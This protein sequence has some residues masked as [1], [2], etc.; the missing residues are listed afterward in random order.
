MS[1]A[2]PVVQMSL[3]NERLTL[4]RLEQIYLPAFPQPRQRKAV[5]S[6]L[7][8]VHSLCSINPLDMTLKYPDGTVSISTLGEL[9]HYFVCGEK[10][11]EMPPDAPTFLAFLKT[12]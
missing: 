10:I 11:S 7:E 2:S 1:D 12:N 8:L 9:L 5:L 6:L 4:A 3:D